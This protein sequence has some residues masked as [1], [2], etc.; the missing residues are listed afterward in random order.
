[1]TEDSRAY[2]AKDLSVTPL[3]VVVA[4]RA[5]ASPT[6]TVLHLQLALTTSAE[7]LA[8]IPALV[9]KTPSAFR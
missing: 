8:R 7:I 4:N 3:L 6:L 2:V 5:T 9:V 1:M